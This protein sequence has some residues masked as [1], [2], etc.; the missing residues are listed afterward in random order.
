MGDDNDLFY[1]SRN[2]WLKH[3]RYYHVVFIKGMTMN[4]SL[5]PIQC[6]LCIEVVFVHGW[7]LKVTLRGFTLGP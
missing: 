1:E 5:E 4:L 6:S 3:I 7:S 2:T